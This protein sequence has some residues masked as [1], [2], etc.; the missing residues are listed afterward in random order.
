M[1]EDYKDE[2]FERVQ[3]V[4]DHFHLIPVRRITRGNDRLS[5]YTIDEKYGSGRLRFFTDNNS[6]VILVDVVFHE[7]YPSPEI[8]RELIYISYY[9]I[10]NVY[11]SADF[12]EPDKTI[13]MKRHTIYTNLALDKGLKSVFQAG[14]P[15]KG[16]ILVHPRRND[17]SLQSEN[18][19]DVLTFPELR[20]MIRSLNNQ[21][22]RKELAL[23]YYQLRTFNSFDLTGLLYYKAKMNEVIATLLS[24]AMPGNTKKPDVEPESAKPETALEEISD[25]LDHIRTHLKERPGIEELAQIAHMS[26][27]KLKYTFKA[28]TGQTI[29]EFRRQLRIEASEK[30]LRTTDW[31]IARIADEVGFHSASHFTAFFKKAAG[32]TPREFRRMHQEQKFVETNGTGNPDSPLS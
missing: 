22:N 17:I 6:I 20:R 1:N 11:I 28:A 21:E 7:D 8:V 14:K 29:G 2:D 4:I 16:I 13:P 12:L 27:S 19:T 32:M 5:D 10:A 23:I 30:M 3:S 25:I 15:S 31:D 18:H 26:P 24:K 9:D